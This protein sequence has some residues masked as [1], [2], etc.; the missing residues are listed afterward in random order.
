MA[1]LFPTKKTHFSNILHAGWP[2]GLVVG[3][4]ISAAFT[5]ESILG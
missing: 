3:G 5:G 4:L 1:T 2:A